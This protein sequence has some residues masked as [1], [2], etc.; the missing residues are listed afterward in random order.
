ME[1]AC[2]Q[3]AP[4]KPGTKR[5]LAERAKDLGLEQPSIDLLSNSSYVALGNYVDPSKEE[6]NT[7]T[8]VEKG[9]VHIMAQKMATDSDTLSFMREL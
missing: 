4:F 7:I 6:L 2:F 8:K 9:I 5:S 1:Y 3:Y